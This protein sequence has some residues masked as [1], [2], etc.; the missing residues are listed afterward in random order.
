MS[1][2]EFLRLGA[3]H[4]VALRRFPYP[5]RAALALSSDPDFM[6]PAAFWDVHDFMNGRGLTP[7]GPGLGLEVTDA[8][9]FFAADPARSL[10]YFEGLSTRPS[11]DAGWLAEL[12]RL[13]W[14]DTVHAWG[15]LDGAGGFTR[16]HAGAAL[17]ALD[18]LGVTL[19]VWTNHGTEDNTQNLGGARPR[20][21]R[22]DRPG[23][24]EYHA[25]LTVGHGVSF[26]WLD[27]HATDVF[28]QGVRP[29]LRPLARGLR[30]RLPPAELLDMA[31][32]RLLV[33]EVLADGRRVYGVR[34][35]RGPWR[36][37]P[38]S[39]PRQLSASH[40]GRLVRLGGVG[41]V[42]Q[43]LGV[44]RA[45]GVARPSTPPHLPPDA[46]EALGRLA[47]AHHRGDILVLGLERLLRYEVVHAGLEFRVEP[48]P[49]IVI[50]H[51]DDWLFGRFRPREEDLAGITFYAPSP[52]QAR[53]ERLGPGGERLPIRHANHPPDE[54]GRA[55]LSVPR[56]RLDW[57]AR[58]RG[59]AS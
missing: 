2:A 34:R 17:D 22:G 35:Y 14:I 24:A 59:I 26:V 50:E 38:S 18:R 12:L 47:A 23:A 20:Y 1:T 6:Q 49:V 53:L 21:Q 46:V 30:R 25:D 29:G 44:D 57:P 43:H 15:D 4:G 32:N 5:Y 27:H 42:Y 51:V 16:A 36:P 13:G 3:R 19:R 37:D 45:S 8:C 52:G 7:L 11:R 28:G 40:L 54:T 31:R 41:V 39:L 10:A 48:G 58:P 56:P 9:F 55:S 33:P